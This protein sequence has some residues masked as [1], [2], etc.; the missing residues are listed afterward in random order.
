[1]LSFPSPQYTSA[2]ETV[3]LSN[4]EFINFLDV[5]GNDKVSRVDLSGLTEVG[6]ATNPVFSNLY[7]RFNP[8]LVSVDLG[9]LESLL[10]DLKVED[11][12]MLVRSCRHNLIHNLIH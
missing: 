10:R 6:S 7:I 9:A 12:P 1:M 3:D 11:N 8:R 4:L 2:L 5:I